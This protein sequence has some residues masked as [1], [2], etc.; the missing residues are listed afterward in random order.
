MDQELKNKWVTALRSGDYVQGSGIMRDRHNKFCCLGVLADICDVPIR[1]LDD[2][3]YRYDFGND[4]IRAGTP[5]VGWQGLTES[6]IMTLSG[7]N[8]SGSDFST[9]ALYIEDTL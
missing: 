5:P 9:I 2:T 7:M 6:D 1:S 3:D 4:M 8:D